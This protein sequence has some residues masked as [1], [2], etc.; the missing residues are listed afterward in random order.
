MT[1]VRS[2]TTPLISRAHRELTVD[3]GLE[4]T[5]FGHN[6]GYLA[7]KSLHSKRLVSMVLAND[8]KCKYTN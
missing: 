5:G 2:G 4:S 8:I 1:A 7:K 6:D 3:S